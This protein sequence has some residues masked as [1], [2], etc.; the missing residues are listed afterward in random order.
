[1][2]TS[3]SSSVITAKQKKQVLANY[4]A[5]L[6]ILK[7][8]EKVVR[9]NIKELSDEDLSPKAKLEL[10]RQSDSLL[11]EIQRDFKAVGKSFNL[12]DRKKPEPKKQR[13]KIKKT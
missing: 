5:T 6:S 13:T 9:L 4:E 2:K 1:M 3:K 10:H 7:K 11:E 12:M 8:M